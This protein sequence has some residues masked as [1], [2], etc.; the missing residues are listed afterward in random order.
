MFMRI[1][2]KLGGCHPPACPSGFLAGSKMK[3]GVMLSFQIHAVDVSSIRITYGY[4]GFHGLGVA[5]A[6]MVELPYGLLRACRSVCG[7]RAGGRTVENNFSESLHGSS[8]FFRLP[9]WQRQ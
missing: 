1:P 4:G 7:N 8:R 9:E 2:G 5:S 3:N 6:W